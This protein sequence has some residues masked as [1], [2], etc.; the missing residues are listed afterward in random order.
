MTAIPGPGA[1]DGATL[2]QAITDGDPGV[3]DELLANHEWT[4]VP[5]KGAGSP[6]PM[7]QRPPQGDTERTPCSISRAP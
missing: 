7:H 4:R 6:W 5:R 3:M 1:I 2:L